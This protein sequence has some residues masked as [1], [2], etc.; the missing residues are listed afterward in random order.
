MIICT[1]RCAIEWAQGITI[2]ANRDDVVISFGSDLVVDMTRENAELLLTR[3]M[4]SLNKL[5]RRL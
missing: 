5:E 1:V 2:D 3:L 4:E